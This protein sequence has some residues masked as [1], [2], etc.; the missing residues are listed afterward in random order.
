MA[1]NVS[2]QNFLYRDSLLTIK[3]AIPVNSTIMERLCHRLTGICSVLSSQSRPSFLAHDLSPDFNTSDTTGATSG[4]GS[5]YHSAAPK[6]THKGFCL[7]PT[8]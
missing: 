8:L 6:I 1:Q 7:F 2:Y 4:A 5:A 3:E